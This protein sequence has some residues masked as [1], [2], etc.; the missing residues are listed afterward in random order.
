VQPLAEQRP[1]SAWRQAREGLKAYALK[2][3]PQRCEQVACLL[4]ALLEQAQLPL[5]GVVLPVG[6]GFPET[7]V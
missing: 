6:V 7:N 1:D 5:A 4:Q 3:K 2:F